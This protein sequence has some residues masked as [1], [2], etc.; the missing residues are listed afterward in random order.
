MRYVMY[1]QNLNTYLNITVNDCQ[2]RCDE[3]EECQSFDYARKQEMC[4][5]NRE[6]ATSKPELFGKHKAMDYYQK[7]S[8]DV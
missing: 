5:L 6:T 8:C 3:M 1:G 2:D 4:L 7:V